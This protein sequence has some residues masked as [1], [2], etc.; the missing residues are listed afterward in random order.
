M[1]TI[2]ISIISLILLLAFSKNSYPQAGQLDNTFGQGGIVTTALNV[3]GKSQINS[4]AMQSDGKLIAAGVSNNGTNADFTIARYNP[5]GSL[6]NSFGI[7]GIVITQIG[8]TNECIQSVKIQTDGKIITGGYSIKDSV[9]DFALVRYNPDGSLDSEFGTNGIV[10][11]QVG[12]KDDKIFSIA[13]QSDGKIVAGGCYIDSSYWSFA[14]VRYNP[15]GSLDDS[16]GTNGIVTTSIGPRHDVINTVLIQPDGKIVAVGYSNNG[17]D[18][19]FAVA[20]Y[21]TNGFLDDGFG[22][23]GIVTTPIGTGHDAAYPAVLQSDGKIIAACYSR[24]DN[25]EDFALA[26][27]NPNGTL[28]NTFGENGKVITQVG[29]S[30]DRIYSL[31]IQNDGKIVAAGHSY[32]TTHDF[33][34]ARYNMDGS[35]DESFGSNGISITPVGTL[36]DIAFSVLIQSDGKIVAAGY[37]VQNGK[38]NFAVVRYDE[39]GI[40]D[41]SFGEYGIVITPVGIEASKAYSVKIQNDGKIIAAGYTLIDS[42]YNFAVVRFN[43]NGSRDNS[44]GIN[45]VV[46]TQI[47]PSSSIAYSAAIQNDGKI[48]IGGKSSNGSNNDFC[49]ARYNING[50]LDNSFGTDGI[51]TTEIGT[52]TDVI[53]TIAIQTNESGVEKIIAAGQTYNGSNSDF[54]LTRYNINGALDMSFGNNGIV[55]TDIETRIDVIKSVVLQGDGKILALGYSYY[56]GNSDFALAR[57]NTDGTLD[58]SFSGN[59][60]VI[61]QVGDAG[62]YGRALAIQND[63][64]IVAAGYSFNGTYCD[65]ALTRYNIDGSPDES[66]AT[67]GIFT[68]SYGT[69]NDFVYSTAVQNDG[70]IIAAGGGRS[71]IEGY[72]LILSRYKP[73][74]SI[75]STFGGDGVIITPVGVSSSYALSMALQDDGKIVTAGCSDNDNGYCVF[76]LTRYN[77][78]PATGISSGNLSELPTSFS[79]EQ[80]YPNP[81][82]PTTTIRFSIP[83]RQNVNLA[84]YDLLG[85][86]VKALV[87]RELKAGRHSFDFNAAGFASG[88]YIYRLQ[89]ESFISARRCILLK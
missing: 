17:D 35:L 58:N 16:F 43:S 36:A 27:Y 20:R 5:D 34:V 81:F 11:T 62:D 12:D 84:I 82:N 8:D 44:F 80:N 32:S 86:K 2:M 61:T 59:G 23:H 73:D 79:L 45:G 69:L 1:K 75:D 41:N 70:K 33:A 48:I 63:G 46:S 4:I 88:I 87:N 74:G 22:T 19:D 21:N 56:E 26:R 25:G 64:K 52:S 78:D 29:T 85:R 10:T 76:S 37:S 14:V 89:T 77:S 47:G 30:Q 60:I 54:A 55:T 42:N 57:Y 9:N 66:F 50:T 13:L 71:D 67:N 65:F 7:N 15:D 6:D 83:K 40:N 18:Y 72:D 3:N 28:D 38:N 53:E 39:D 51:V 68:A 24:N 49:L 31:A